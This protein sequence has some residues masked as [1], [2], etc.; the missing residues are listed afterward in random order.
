MVVP[1]FQFEQPLLSLLSQP[2]KDESN[3]QFGAA[4]KQI[5]M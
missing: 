1:V 2:H 5:A 4:K 3:V